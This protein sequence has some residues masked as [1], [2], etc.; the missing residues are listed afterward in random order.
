MQAVH[1]AAEI[2]AVY[3]SQCAEISQ[4]VSSEDDIGIHK[5]GR[6]LGPGI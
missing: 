1:A 5:Y 4:K 3:Q 2:Q 6:C